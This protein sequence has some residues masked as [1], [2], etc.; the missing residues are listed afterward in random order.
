MVRPLVE[1]WTKLHMDVQLGQ[2]QLR[3]LVQQAKIRCFSSVHS[4][5]TVSHTTQASGV[6]VTGVSDPSDVAMLEEVEAYIAV[7]V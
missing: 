5:P 4:L 1:V 7:N 2:K 6:Y 3:R